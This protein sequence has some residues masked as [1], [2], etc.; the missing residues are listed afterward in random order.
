MQTPIANRLQTV[1]G[2]VQQLPNEPNIE[3]ERIRRGSQANVA[4]L[5]EQLTRNEQVSG[6]NPLVGSIFKAIQ[7]FRYRF[8]GAVC[9]YGH[10]FPVHSSDVSRFVLTFRVRS[11]FA[12]DR[13]RRVILSYN[14]TRRNEQDQP[15]ITSV[16][17][18]PTLEGRSER[19]T[20]T[21]L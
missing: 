21:T 11:R 15:Y 8:G 19:T 1:S 16:R 13:T 17:S 7:H 5:V 20:K 2:V 6:S 4:Q 3:S 9:L 14:R 12:L 10:L 18:G